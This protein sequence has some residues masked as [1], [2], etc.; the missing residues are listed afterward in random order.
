[1]FPTRLIK[2]VNN[3]NIAIHQLQRL[4]QPELHSNG[5]QQIISSQ[6]GNINMVQTNDVFSNAFSNNI[7]V[8]NSITSNT[9]QNVVV[10]PY[11]IT[12]THN[13]FC[14]SNAVED[15]GLDEVMKEN[16]VDE[17]NAGSLYFTTTTVKEFTSRVLKLAIRECYHIVEKFTACVSY[18][19]MQKIWKRYQ[20][21]IENVFQIC[22]RNTTGNW[23]EDKCSSNLLMCNYGS[24]N[25]NVSYDSTKDIIYFRSTKL[26][27]VYATFSRSNEMTSANKILTI[28]PISRDGRFQVHKVNS[29]NS[30]QVYLNKYF[31]INNGVCVG[32]NMYQKHPHLLDRQNI[33]IDHANQRIWFSKCLIELAPNSNRK[34]CSSCQNEH[35]NIVKYIYNKNMAIGNTTSYDHYSKDD[36]LKKVRNQVAES[37][38]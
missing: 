27:Q 30:L 29:K 17:L 24:S 34:Q 3:Q 2:V 6:Y 32:I 18:H 21:D 36:L 11:E 28:L 8:V 1:M 20:H 7:N 19:N 4:L 37:K 15:N 10:T 13:A 23:V 12:N 38:N 31:G 5:N 22:P 35:K 26:S 14:D 33:S 16:T 25:L 9:H